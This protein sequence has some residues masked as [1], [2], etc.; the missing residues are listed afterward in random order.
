MTVEMGILK[1]LTIH[2]CTCESKP[3]YLIPHL[4]G[5][6]YDAVRDSNRVRGPIREAEIDSVFWRGQEIEGEVGLHPVEGSRALPL[7]PSRD[8]Q[9]IPGV[10]ESQ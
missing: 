6:D 5:I 7:H 1:G 4:A 3:C 8:H 9:P 2:A 10:E